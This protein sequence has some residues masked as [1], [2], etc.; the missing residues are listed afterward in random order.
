MVCCSA[1][2]G[3]ASVFWVLAGLAGG[4]LAVAGLSIW[5]GVWPPGA[6]G[7][8]EIG[9]PM[10]L[11]PGGLRAQSGKP[12]RAALEP[13]TRPPGAGL[14]PPTLA[15][16]YPKAQRHTAPATSHIQYTS[17]TTA[18]DKTETVIHNL[19]ALIICSGNSREDHA[20]NRAILEGKA[21]Q[22]AG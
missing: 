13:K 9:L 17:N 1:V 3:W 12:G 16:A 18:T 22:Y 11:A 8:W 15:P 21:N 2:S 19:T 4:C 5:L 10:L 6:G 14:K 20:L 7:W